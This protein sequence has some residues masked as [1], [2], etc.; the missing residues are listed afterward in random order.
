M[1]FDGNIVRQLRLHL[2]MLYGPEIQYRKYSN[3]IVF[4]QHSL[5]LRLNLGQ[6]FLYQKFSCTGLIQE[7]FYCNGSSIGNLVA[8]H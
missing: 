8:G 3:V 6:D 5:K 7:R 1:P 4:E 2:H